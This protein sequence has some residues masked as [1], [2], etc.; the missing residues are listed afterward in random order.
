MILYLH[1]LNSSGASLKA[2]QL[3]AALGPTE[4]LSPSYPAHRPQSAVA[5]LTAFL[6]R[7]L[8]EHSRPEPWLWVGSSMGAFYGRYLAQRF[9]VRHLVLINPALRPWELLAAYRGETFTT[10]SGESYLVDGALIEATR[11]YAVEESAPEPPT[12]LFLDQGDEVIDWR[13]AEAIYRDR[14]RVLSFPGGD[15]AFAHLARALPIIRDTYW[16]LG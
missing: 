8:G 3:R 4:V 12:T 11:L 1:G 9:A 5:A 14:A 2:A 7:R 10:A 13:I 6:Q 16:A 15:H